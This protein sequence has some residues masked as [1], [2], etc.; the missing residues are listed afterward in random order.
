MMEIPDTIAGLYIAAQKKGIM[1]PGI[2]PYVLFFSMVHSTDMYG[3]MSKCRPDSMADKILKIPEQL[4]EYIE[5]II[6]IYVEGV[7]L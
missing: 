1:K 7:L 4:D 6:T 3:H 2:H 5:Q